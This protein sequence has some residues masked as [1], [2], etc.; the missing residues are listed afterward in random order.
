MLFTSQCNAIDRHPQLL[1]RAS[2]SRTN[3]FAIPFRRSSFRTA[4]FAMYAIPV[5]HR[6]EITPRPSTGGGGGV[7]TLPAHFK[8]RMKCK[9]EHHLISHTD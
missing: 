4:T 5:L 1:A 3:I 8:K 9:L 2:A 6:L 7:W